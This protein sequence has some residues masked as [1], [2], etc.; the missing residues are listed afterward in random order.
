MIPALA[1]RAAA[2]LGVLAAG[3]ALLVL[4]AARRAPV[5]VDVGPSTGAI[6]SGF[7]ESEERPPLTF[8]WARR[9]AALDVPV[10]TRGGAATITLRAARFLDQPATVRV[11]LSGRPAGTFTAAPGGFRIHHLAADV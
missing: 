5:T 7:T 3:E 9:A 2:I 8:R 4:A 11:F 6:G 10:T 1:L